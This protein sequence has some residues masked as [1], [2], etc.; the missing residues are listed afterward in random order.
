[1]S[2]WLPPVGTGELSLVLDG[3]V[4]SGTVGTLLLPVPGV[5]ERLP[6]TGAEDSGVGAKVGNVS[7][8]AEE[9]V[10]GESST[11]DEV[12]GTELV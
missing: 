1:M 4:V 11:V 3:P 5:I 12:S 8:G 10:S 2:V 7:S 9:A 6:K